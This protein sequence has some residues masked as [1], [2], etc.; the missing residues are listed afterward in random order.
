[1]KNAK[2]PWRLENSVYAADT[3]IHYASELFPYQD[4][5][6]GDSLT[7]MGRQQHRRFDGDPLRKCLKS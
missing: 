7:R 1:M 5:F 4:V 6:L 3:L 2:N